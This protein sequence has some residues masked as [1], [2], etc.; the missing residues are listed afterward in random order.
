MV[1]DSHLAWRSLPGSQVQKEVVAEDAIRLEM[2]MP[3]PL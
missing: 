2:T 1:A 3:M